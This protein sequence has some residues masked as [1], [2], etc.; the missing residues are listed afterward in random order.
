MMHAA[1]GLWFAGFR[2]PVLSA[3]NIALGL[4]VHIV[5]VWDTAIATG[6]PNLHSSLT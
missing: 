3:Q 5:L 4:I 2:L 1:R 6:R